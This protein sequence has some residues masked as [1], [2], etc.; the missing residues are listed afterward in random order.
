M[1]NALEAP[2]RR[3]GERVLRSATSGVVLRFEGRELDNEKN[4]EASGVMEGSMIEATGVDAV[5][6]RAFTAELERQLWN[7]REVRT[8]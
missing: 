2:L 7:V 8:W 3:T 6:E 5:C 1:I 4:L